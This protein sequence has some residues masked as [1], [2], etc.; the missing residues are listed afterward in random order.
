[1]VV[2]NTSMHVNCRWYTGSGLYRSVELCHG[3][4]VHIVNDGVFL[5]TKEVAD[6]Y[7]FLECEVEVENA[8]LENRLANVQV[9]LAEA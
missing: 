7:A 1:M 3:P 8:T 4:R 9:S 5:R 6:G 2:V